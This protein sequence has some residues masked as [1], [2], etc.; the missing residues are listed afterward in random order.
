MGAWPLV[1]PILVLLA[2]SGNLTD[3]LGETATPPAPHPLRKKGDGE[4]RWP[5]G[6]REAPGLGGVYKRSSTLNVSPLAEG[7]D[8]GVW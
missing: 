6:E 5:E 1:C 2:C 8:I 4:R 7:D 3:F